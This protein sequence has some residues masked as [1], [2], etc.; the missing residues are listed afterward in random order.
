M[1]LDA[2]ATTI[3]YEISGSGPPLL[4]SHGVI[5][6]SASWEELA[7]LLGRHFQVIAHDARA[8]GRSGWDGRPFGYPELAADVESLASH[9]GLE[10]FCHVG[11]SMGGRVVLEHA[12]V[13]PWRV[14]GLAVVSA[15]AE[16]PADAGR[17]RLRDLMARARQLG[18]GAAV[19]MWTGPADAH[20]DRVR[21]IS[22][23]S[24][25]AGTCAALEALIE[26]ESLV[27][28]LDEI[29]VPTLVLSG[30]RDAGY[31]RSAFTMAR[32]IPGAT[33]QVL[34]G[35]GHFPNFECPEALAEA[36]VHFFDTA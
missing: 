2:G 19:D 23:T 11:H 20:Y 7:P 30:N 18:P 28:R 33:L 9:L 13:N 5:E 21:S 3:N 1:M 6:S 29:R 4:L 14:R 10:R 17:Q 34:E 35:A 32:H 26:M 24:S 8:R 16:A 25:L 22:A 31:L 27:P 15:R 12:L 36:L